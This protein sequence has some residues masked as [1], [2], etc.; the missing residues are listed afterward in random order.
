MELIDRYVH[1][2]GEHLPERIREDVETELR[3]LLMDAVEARAREASRPVDE[4]IASRVLREFGRPQEVARRYAPEAEYLIGPRLFPA[5]KRVMTLIVIVFAALFLASIVLGILKAVQNPEGGFTP[6]PLLG[7]TWQLLKSLLFN[8]AMLTLAFAVVER[9]RMRQ[10]L[11]GKEWDPSKLRAMVSPERISLIGGVIQIYLTL[12]VA[13]LFNFYP[14]WIG[15]AVVNRGIVVQSILLPEFARYLPVLNILFAASIAY[16][17]WTLRVGYETPATRW[18]ELVLGFIGAGVLALIITGPP[19][20]RYNTLV[21]QALSLWL[22]LT[23][24]GCARRLYRIIARKDLRPW[25]SAGAQ[26]F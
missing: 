9:V 13:V 26:L 15:I 11:A 18:G 5:Y 23:L 3:S 1:E 8:F 16:N 4:E 17:L 12:I 2:V 6:A 20:F 19:V 25:K 14:Q 24:F 10:E 21:K 7:G 22:L